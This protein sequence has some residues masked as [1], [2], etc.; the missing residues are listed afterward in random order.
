S[1]P[2]NGLLG[3]YYN[4]PD[5]TG[6]FK[7]RYDATVDYDWGEAAPFSGVNPDR[8]SVRWI[9][10]LTPQFTENYTFYTQSDD[11]VRLYI[12]TNLIID[13][14][15]EQMNIRTS[16]P[17]ML[18]AGQKY[19]FRM[20]MFEGSARAVAKLYWS[21]PSMPRTTIPKSCFTPGVPPDPASALAY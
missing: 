17:M 21:S 7:I 19:D 15:K 6:G 8:F 5:H 14:W 3:L 16:I 1:M 12:N 2:T 11:G 10:T 18:F 4:E 13:A 20:E 9:G